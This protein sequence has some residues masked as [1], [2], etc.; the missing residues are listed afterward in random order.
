MSVSECVE[1]QYP[2]AASIGSEDE[3]VNVQIRNP[4]AS[5]KSDWR[6]GIGEKALIA[7]RVTR[8]WNLSRTMT[9]LSKAM[10]FGE[11]VRMAYATTN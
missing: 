11:W 1:Y 3:C 6:I 10:V 9:Q 7:M 8:G 5:L 2:Y 4:Y